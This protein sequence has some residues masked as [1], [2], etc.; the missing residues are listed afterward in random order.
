[1]GA[2]T[3]ATSRPSLEVGCQ[4]AATMPIVSFLTRE[5]DFTLRED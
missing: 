5:E 3:G 1:M 2:G 4:S